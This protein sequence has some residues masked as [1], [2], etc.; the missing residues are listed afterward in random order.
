MNKYQCVSR[1]VKLGM[2][3]K[4]SKFVN[5]YG[6]AIGDDTK[7]GA[8]VEVQK[9]AVIGRNCKI[10]SHAFIC[11]GVT[12]DDGCFIGHGVMFINDNY[13]KAVNKRGALES[14]KDWA[15]RFV[16]THIKENVSIGSNA[17]I[18]GNITIGRNAIIGAGSVVTKDVGSGQVWAG[19]PARPIK[20][21]RKR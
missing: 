13:P 20:A 17:T 21:T 14:E 9:N 1:N 8:F 12:I 5:L 16:K 19:N 11:E 7:I 4:L 6:C 15:G 2:N 3:V 18:L 10:S